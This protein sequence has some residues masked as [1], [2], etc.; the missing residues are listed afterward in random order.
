[1]SNWRPD[2]DPD[3]LYFVTTTAVHHAHVFRRDV[4]K[5]LLLD[6]LDCMR[7]QQRLKL[8][9]F[10]IMPN[11]VHLIVQCTASDSVADVV[12]DYKHVTADRLVRQL[13]AEDNPSALAF[14]ASQV[15]RPTRQHHKVWEDDYNAKEVVSPGFLQQKM[16]YIHN[17]PCQ[18]HWNLSSSPEAYIWSSARFYAS[19]ARCIIP[20]D[21][22]RDLL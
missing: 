16:T 1:M 5:R 7:H 3:H 14:L 12:R 19:D 9:S 2:F 11:H 20:V 15:T 17:N 4:I 22:A 18:P 21:D 6:T 8:F 10:V 13:E